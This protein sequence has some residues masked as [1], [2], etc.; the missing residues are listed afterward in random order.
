MSRNPVA[1]QDEPAAGR[2]GAGG[3][4]AG[5]AAAGATTA[6]GEAAKPKYQIKPLATLKSKVLKVSSRGL[7]GAA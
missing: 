2:G 4:R 7:R 5:D 1:P 6:S 3:R